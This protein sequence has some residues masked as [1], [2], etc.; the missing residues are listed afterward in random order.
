MLCPPHT[1]Y[2]NTNIIF[3]SPTFL[4]IFYVIKYFLL[5]QITKFWYGI[6]YLYLLLHYNCNQRLE[7]GNLFKISSI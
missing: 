5:K 6:I 2:S 7:I 1:P 4:D 3:L